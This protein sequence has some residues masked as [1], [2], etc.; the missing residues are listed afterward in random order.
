MKRRSGVPVWLTGFAVCIASL[1]VGAARPAAATDDETLSAILDVLRE[2]GLID[3]ERHAEL[4]AKARKKAEK[5]EWLD[6]ISIWGDFRG[7][8]E[9]FLYDDDPVT[10]AMGEHL[11][12]RHRARYRARL[13]LSADV[14]SRAT[15][16]LRMVSG[17]DD[18]RSTN[19]TLGR[20][21]DFDTDD[22]RL[23]LAYM[24][25]TPTPGGEL[26]FLEDGYF[27]I[28]FGKVKNPFVS[29]ALGPGADSVIWDND[30]TLEGTS[31]RFR[32]TLGPVRFSANGGWYIVDENSLDPA[33][34]PQLLGGQLAGETDLL[35]D[36]VF[37]ARGTIYHYFSLDDDFFTRGADGGNI[38]D[39][40]SR[41]NG[42]IQIVETSGYLRLSCWELAPVYVFGTY[43]H[44]LSA[45]TSLATG[46]SRNDDAYSAGILVG[47]PK[48]LVELGFAWFRVEANALPSMF[49]D[50][51]LLDGFTNRE[52]YVWRLRRELIPSIELL[53]KVFLLDAI[54]DGPAY[55][56]SV[57]GSERLRMQVDL[58]LKF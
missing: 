11:P 18:P 7:R 21:A 10:E 43:A 27:G 47:D 4:E 44:N 30:I 58:V 22:F 49:M 55:V 51:D 41:R 46:A 15:V 36:L 28:D 54:H 19:Q 2:E 48:A 53:Y 24:T 20:G 33:K 50:S 5:R 23:D 8:Y 25:L 57:E 32:S 52:G 1:G 26:D 42:S 34:D 56:D 14:A 39:G 35:D 12:D 31:A 16:Y 37:G 3:E 17:D 45:R 29:K 9:N 6:R 13:N 38:V 40:L